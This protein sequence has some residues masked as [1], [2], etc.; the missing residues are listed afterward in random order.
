M[1]EISW[2]AQKPVMAIVPVAKRVRAEIAGTV[3]ADSEH[4]LLLLERG[5]APVYYFPAA[6]VA[7]A[8]LTHSAHKTHCPKK[9]DASYWT[10]T[11]GERRLENAVWGYENPITAAAPIAGHFAFYWD[12][13]DRWLEEDE[14]LLGHPRSPFHRVDIRPTSRRVRVFVAGEPVAETRRARLLFETGFPRRCY[15]PREDVTGLRLDPSA[16]RTICP[17]KGVASYWSAH[18][19]GNQIADIA[20]SYEDPLLES[21]AIKGLLSFYPDKVERIEIDRA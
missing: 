1:D 10:L 11:V 9:G 17:Y 16:T 15:I 7:T 14:V 5:H 19:G 21:L 13:V 6:D 4:A 3:V 20:W 8:H 18:A 2:A 12:K